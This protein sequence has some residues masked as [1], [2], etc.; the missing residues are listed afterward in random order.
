MRSPSSAL[1]TSCA[2]CRS[3]RINGS[4]SCARRNS[5]PPCVLPVSNSPTRQGWSITRSPMNGGLA[6][7]PTSITSRR[8][9]SAADGLLL[10]ATT[11]AWVSLRPARRKRR[12]CRRGA[13]LR[14]VGL[15]FLLLFVAPHLAF[16]HVIL[17]PCNLVQ[18]IILRLSSLSQDV[19]A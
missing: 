7:I 10:G 4:A 17:P 18:S 19:P 9:F 16:G 15:R 5:P 3:A 14:L 13:A 12:G 8:Q 2:G 1:S 11:L 6:P